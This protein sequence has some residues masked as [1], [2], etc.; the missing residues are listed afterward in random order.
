MTTPLDELFAIITVHDLSKKVLHLLT[1]ANRL[2]E[3]IDEARAEFPE[4]VSIESRLVTNEEA[5]STISGL[6]EQLE[7]VANIQDSVQLL[8]RLIQLLPYE[9]KEFHKKLYEN[10]D[11]ADTP[12]PTQVYQDLKALRKAL[13]P[14]EEFL[15]QS[16]KTT[17]FMA[18]KLSDFNSEGEES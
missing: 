10:V 3:M 16:L 14:Y 13:R 1:H 9:F 7:E 15:T 18:Y 2:E 6:L 8:I 5:H 11:D 4:A 17:T 12:D